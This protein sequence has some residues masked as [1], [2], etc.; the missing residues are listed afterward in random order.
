MQQLRETGRG[1][2]LLQ[3]GVRGQLMPVH[4]LTPEAPSPLGRDASIAMCAG[5]VGATTP[6]GPV[7]RRKRNVWGSYPL[8]F[9]ALTC[10][11]SV[12]VLLHVPNSGTYQHSAAA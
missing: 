11:Y 4:N 9:E 10:N 12:Y 8:L 1:K 2:L 7:R 5:S 6:L 3:R